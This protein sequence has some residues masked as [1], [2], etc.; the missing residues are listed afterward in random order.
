MNADFDR[1]SQ[2]VTQLSHSV[3]A[4]N[5]DAARIEQKAVE[6]T[7]KTDMADRNVSRSDRMVQESYNSFKS[8]SAATL[9]TVQ[10]LYEII[11]Q[12]S[13]IQHMADQALQTLDNIDQINT[14]LGNL[15]N[16]QEQ[17]RRAG[18]MQIV[19]LQST[20]KS[21]RTIKLPQLT[22]SSDREAVKEGSLIEMTFSTIGGIE[23][24]FDLEIVVEKEGPIR[25]KGL[26]TNSNGAIARTGYQYFVEFIYHGAFV[27]DFALIKVFPVEDSHAKQA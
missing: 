6:L 25:L 27:N 8:T 18:I 7:A 19:L 17:L 23:K 10:R 26:E 20:G 4:V 12:P 1:Y 3:D 21:A 2:Q 5:Q 24:K 15:Q 11:P 14:K 16:V 9:G 22:S 13:E